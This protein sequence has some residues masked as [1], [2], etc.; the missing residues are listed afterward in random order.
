MA[1]FELKTDNFTTAFTN[2]RVTCTDCDFDRV[3]DGPF[4]TN[5]DQWGPFQEAQEHA[6]NHSK[7]TQADSFAGGVRFRFLVVA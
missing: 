3:V 6:R 1:G 4:T 2:G 7:S 5:R